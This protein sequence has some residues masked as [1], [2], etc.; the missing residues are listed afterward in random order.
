MI[1]AKIVADSIG[2]MGDRLTSFVITFP[3]IILAELNTH[4]MLSKNSASSRAIPFNK[5]VESV[6]N[7][8]FTPLAWQKEHK[9]MQGTEYI[10]GRGVELR[11]KQ[12]LLARDNAVDLAKSLNSP[13]ETFGGE[14]IDDGSVVTK[15]L[16]NRLLEPFMWHTVLIT[17]GEEGLQNFFDLRCPQYHSPVDTHFRHKSK[18]DC[19]AAHNAPKNLEI[20]NNFTVVDWLKI[21]EGQAEIHMM[22]LA[23][24]MY[25]VYNSSTPINLYPGEWHVPFREQIDTLE[26]QNY[27]DSNHS[28]EDLM[29]MVATAMAA[30]VSYTVIGEEKEFG[31]EKQLE[32][33]EKLLTSRH[34]SPFEHCARVMDEVEYNTWTRGRGYEDWV[35]EIVYD[36]NAKGWCKNYKGFIQLR[37]ILED[38]KRND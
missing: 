4:R 15:Q 9:G 21:N 7:N 10:T 31:Y 38:A 3:R 33:Y 5:M 8:P 22:E 6:Q 35:N 27:M 19:I 23:E 34:Y 37:Q 14:S 32:L 12:W 25:D 29:I 16:C 1:S 26:L 13:L 30:R 24:V 36:D 2:P 11:N 28:F 20:F 18:K 17:G